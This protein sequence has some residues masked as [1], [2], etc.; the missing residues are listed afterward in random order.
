MYN[1]IMLFVKIVEVGSFTRSAK[2]LS[3][4]QST[5]TRRIQRLESNIGFPLIKRNT[6]M[7]ELSDF[8]KKFYNKVKTYPS[9]FDAAI[10]EIKNNRSEISGVLYVTLPPSFARAIITPHLL[11]FIDS[12]PK[13]KLNLNYQNR[14]VNLIQENFDL[15]IVSY[16]PKQQSQKI[17]FLFKS[18]IIFYC[19]P[20]YIKQFGMPKSL[21]EL[22]KR[23]IIGIPDHQGMAR[24]SADI[25]NKH[26]N[27]KYTM[28]LQN[29]IVQNT[30][31]HIDVLARSGK[32]IAVGLDVIL[33]N[34]IAKG[35]VIHLFPDDYIEG[36]DY[37]LMVNPSGMN[38]RSELFI[39]FIE[40]C[41]TCL[42]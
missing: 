22:E 15:A 7:L 1:D 29:R 10:T 33:K 8:G 19:Y 26:T 21:E 30:Q 31:T 35:E 40:D 28:A 9:E 4:S 5:I 25:I 32:T 18:N 20:E 24:K 13:L 11:K 17:R 14:E 12:Y 16:M 41:I 3:I 2:L 23:F 27:N 34:P 38:A 6:R 42:K 39:Q 36:F 37:Y